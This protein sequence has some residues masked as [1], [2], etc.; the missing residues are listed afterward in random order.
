VNRFF[1]RALFLGSACLFATV[2][3]HATVIA[4]FSIDT[5]SLST[6]AGFIDF[7]LNPGDPTSQ[8]LSAFVLNFA[9]DGSLDNS[10][11]QIAGDFSGTLPG[12]LTADNGAADNEYF[13]GLTFGSTVTF[14]L[15]LSGLALDTP[16]PFGSAF[17][18]S[19]FDSTGGNVVLTN[20]PN[21]WVAEL[22]VNPGGSI[23]T[24]VFPDASGGP[25]VADIQIQGAPEPSTMWLVAG[26]LALA[27]LAIRSREL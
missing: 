20:N 18:V 25:S 26:G 4:N 16:A 8:P 9:T 14:T 10:S 3:A 5:S 13:Q 6:Q 22:D 23:T 15:S 2:A 12:T 24:I 11:I 19:F 21:G 7:Q 17:L 27:A 1:Q